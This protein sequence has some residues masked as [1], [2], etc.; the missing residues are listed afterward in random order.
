MSLTRL[1]ATISFGALKQQMLTNKALYEMGMKLGLNACILKNKSLWGEPD[2]RGQVATTVHALIGAVNLD[3][4]RSA[5]EAVVKHLGFMKLVKRKLQRAEKGEAER[6]ANRSA[7]RRQTK[8]DRSALR[9]AEEEN[10]ARKK[11]ADWLRD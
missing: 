7:Q 11:V 2:S 5:T 8:L 6:S 1:T 4:G 3:G 9:R 10:G